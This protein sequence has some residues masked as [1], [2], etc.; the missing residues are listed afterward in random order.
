MEI[1]YSTINLVKSILAAS[2]IA[3]ATSLFL[4]KRYRLKNVD[5]TGKAEIASNH[6]CRAI[7]FRLIF[8]I[9]FKAPNTPM[10][11]SEEFFVFI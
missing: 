7:A 9:K 11:I 10:N 8:I 4:A 2:G 5:R 6:F 3:C 1:S